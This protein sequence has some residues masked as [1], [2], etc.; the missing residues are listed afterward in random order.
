MRLLT[1]FLLSLFSLL[2]FSASAGELRPQDIHI[3]IEQ[4]G[5]RVVVDDLYKIP[6]NWSAL[7]DAVS[8][9]KL[10]WLKVAKELS[11]GTD[12]GTTSMLQIAITNA[13][14][15][16][17]LETLKFMSD[18][19]VNSS[20]VFSA[21]FVCSSSFLIDYPADKN[22]LIFIDRTVEKLKAIKDPTVLKVRDQCVKEFQQAR[23]I[24]LKEI[25]E[26]K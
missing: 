15:N 22:A 5:A 9:G 20:P 7:L 18:K 3:A 25:S 8:T 13:L 4:R 1:I 6:E 11:A 24:T 17:T 12:A 14:G 26:Q 16:N 19:T 10:E 2:S 23:I 21:E